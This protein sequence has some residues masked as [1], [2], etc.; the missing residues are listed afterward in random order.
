MGSEACAEQARCGNSGTTHHEIVPRPVDNIVKVP[1]LV[2][3]QAV[4]VAECEALQIEIGTRLGTTDK[5]SW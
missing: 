3:Q 1:Q 5:T 2:Y 4:E